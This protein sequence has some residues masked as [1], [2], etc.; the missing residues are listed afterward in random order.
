MV[1]LAVRRAL[2]AINARLRLRYRA[3]RRS[4][5]SRIRRWQFCHDL[6]YVRTRRR[7]AHY[8]AQWRHMP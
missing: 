3:L 7:V 5:R 2:T 1:T 6:G 4:R 8:Y